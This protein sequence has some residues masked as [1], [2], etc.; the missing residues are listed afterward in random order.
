MRRR[1][2]FVTSCFVL[3]VAACGG[4]SEPANHPEPAPSATEPTPTPSANTGSPAD[5]DI[6]SGTAAITLGDWSTAKKSFETAVQKDPKK[7]EAH[8]YLGLTL[9]KAGDRAG[10]E[11]HYKEA[12][13]LAPNFTEAATNLMAIDVET[14][15]Y[16]DAIALGKKL[17]AKDEKN[18]NLQLN[19][20]TALSGKGDVDG[21]SKAFERAVAL[22]PNDARFEMA[23]AKHLA[24]AN[25]HDEAVTHLKQ[26]ERVA[27]DDPAL[28]GSIGFEFR[29]ARA[30]PECI[31]AFDKAIAAKDTADFRTNRALCKYAAKDKTGAIAD[32]KAATKAEPSFAPAHYW[33]G[34]FL[35]DDGKFA[36][37]V[38]E[39]D[40]YLKAAPSGPMAKAAEGKAKLAKEKKKPQAAPKR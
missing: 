12:L 30:V 23:F 20:A 18:A 11:S 5:K 21:A 36:E 40:A 10:A 4:S 25:K 29:T 14:Q 37:A 1:H 26:A 6:E 7:P 3:L 22:A 19:L 28:L 27:G 8:Y 15:K 33:L 16:D 2:A 34:S 39:Y 17:L 38:T 9:D 35:H 24:A 31:H 32:L 13:S